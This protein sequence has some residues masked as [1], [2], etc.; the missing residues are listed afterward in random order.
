[1]SIY[2]KYDIN[3]PWSK[4]SYDIS[5]KKIYSKYLY[6]NIL[7]ESNKYYSFQKLHDVIQRGI[8]LLKPELSV[9]V[10][11]AWNDL[12]ITVLQ[13]I[14]SDLCSGLTARYMNFVLAL[15]LGMTPYER[16]R[17]CIEYLLTIPR[18]I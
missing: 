15:G 6:Q 9:Q 4:G 17:S 8:E 13:S 12:V 14:E 3:F 10:F 16:L 5:N 7:N 18:T 11:S 1:M 2:N